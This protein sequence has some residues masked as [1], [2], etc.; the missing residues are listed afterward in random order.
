M[1]EA[2]GDWVDHLY[3]VLWAY[4]T[5][6]QT[7]TG[8][9]PFRPTYGYEAMI[10][11]E[12]GEPSLRK[13]QVSQERVN[14]EAIAAELDLIDEV[15][16][17]AHLRDVATKQ[18]IM[19]RYNKKVKPR[20]FEKDDL[21]LRRADIGNKNAREGKLAANWEGPYRIKEKLGS[22]AYVLETLNG[23]ALKKT[24]NADKLRAYYS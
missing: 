10:A 5:T 15:R 11:V 3:S 14:N 19:A 20:S 6:V 4:R 21:V 9:T 18:L 13:L 24:W 12:I 23:K 7:S 17:T 8:E 22:S 1:E 16:T 2:Q